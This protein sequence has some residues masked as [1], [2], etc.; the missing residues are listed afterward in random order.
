MDPSPYAPAFFDHVG[1]GAINANTQQQQFL[2]FMYGTGPL[3]PQPRYSVKHDD[4]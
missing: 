4:I 2:V 3:P 1:N